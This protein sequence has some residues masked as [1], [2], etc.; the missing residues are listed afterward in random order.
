VIGSQTGRAVR[1]VLL[2]IEGTTT[3]MTF[4]HDVL[5]PFART[6][7]PGWCRSNAGSDRYRQVL[8]RLSEEHVADRRADDPVPDWRDATPDEADRSLQAYVLW[9]MLRDRKTTGLKLLQGLIWEEGYRSGALRGEVY[10]DVPVA[11]RRW[12]RSGI[13]PAIY[14]SGSELA[15][16]RLFGSTIYGDLTTLIAGFFDT[17]VGPKQSPSSYGEVA[18]RLAVEPAEILF[19]SDVTQELSA[20]RAAGCGTV[21]SLRPG[22]RP[23]PD[24]EAYP[25]IRT[26][27]EILP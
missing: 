2:D 9:L 3:P 24:A 10:S 27:D 23:Q 6:S 1:V 14:S 4:V 12:R 11:M 20:A 16:R 13:A 25:H 7:L 15:Q 26:F 21:L 19:V 8:R 18:S 22:N 5:F 17:T